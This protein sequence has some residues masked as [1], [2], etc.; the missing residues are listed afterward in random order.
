V[1]NFCLITRGAYV[2]YKWP[3]RQSGPWM[4]K[5]EIEGTH[6]ASFMNYE[7]EAPYIS[8]STSTAP[9]SEVSGENIDD[10]IK[11]KWVKI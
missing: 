9:Y 7:T 8:T 6:A 2:I 1:K 5:S 11:L 10:F 3:L 4:T